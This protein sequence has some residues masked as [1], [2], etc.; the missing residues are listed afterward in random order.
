MTFKLI[1]IVLSVGELSTIDTLNSILRKD[2]LDVQIV[3]H[4]T[5]QTYN[6][7]ASSVEMSRI[8]F[9]QELTKKGVYGAMNDALSFVYSSKI[10]ASSD[11]FCFL[12]AGDI[13]PDDFNPLLSINRLKTDLK[14]PSGL[15]IFGHISV[16]SSANRNIFLK[17]MYL[18]SVD[19]NWHNVFRGGGV[20]HQAVYFPYRLCRDR[21]IYFDTSLFPFAD[22]GFVVSLLRLNVSLTTLPEF[23]VVYDCKGI[24]SRKPLEYSLKKFF[25][26]ISLPEMHILYLPDLFIFFLKFF[27]R[28]F[29]AMIKLLFYRLP[30]S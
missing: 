29:A 19:Y 9:S 14:Q 5:Q 21:N 11:Y 1:F 13:L 24:S 18:P 6:D 7:L 8:I 27:R 17:K 15:L 20:C 2:F 3:L 30:L 28:I 26:L 4:A 12:N 25:Y 23:A 16:V 10:L 22:L